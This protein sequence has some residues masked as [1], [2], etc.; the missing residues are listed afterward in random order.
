MRLPA[1]TSNSAMLTKWRPAI[2]MTASISACGRD[3]PSTVMVPSQLITVVTPSSS[4]GL[5]V[6]PKPLTRELALAAARFLE[7]NLCGA[8][9]DPVTSP[10]LPRK[11][12]RFHFDLNRIRWLLNVLLVCYGGD[13]IDFYQRISGQGGNCDGCAR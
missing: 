7:N 8:R 11:L 3:P 5:P 6:C 4:K 13:A 9:S 2:I 12:R 1:A 10:T